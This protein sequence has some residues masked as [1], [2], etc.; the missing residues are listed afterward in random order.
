MRVIIISTICFIIFGSALIVYRFFYVRR[1][2]R[3]RATQKLKIFEDLIRKLAAKEKIS[4]DDVSALA[5]NPSTRH[6]LFGILQGFN[7]IDLFP[8]AY[9]TTEKGAESFLVNWLEFPTEL[10]APPDKIELFTKITLQEKSDTID[11][12]VFKYKKLPFA[13]NSHPDMWMLGVAGPYDKESQPF[14]I[15]L[16]VFSRFNELGTVSAMEEASWVHENISKK[17]S[18]H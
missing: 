6:A 18:R 13:G 4:E 16:R 14:D 11:Y 12:F 9:F 2:S 5:K 17:S 3:R 1:K 7:R 8:Q 15:P 10:N